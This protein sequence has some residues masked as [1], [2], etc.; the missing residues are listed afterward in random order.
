MKSLSINADQLIDPVVNYSV[1][2]HIWGEQN[3]SKWILVG[4]VTL[5]ARIGPAPSKCQ[6][7]LIEQSIAK[8]QID[9]YTMELIWM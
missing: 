9:G 2:G 1:R 7:E 3:H 4:S 6:L 8:G 5:T